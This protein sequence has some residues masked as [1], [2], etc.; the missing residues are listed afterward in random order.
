M[1]ISLPVGFGHQGRSWQELEYN[2]PVCMRADHSLVHQNTSF[3]TVGMHL[4]SGHRIKENQPPPKK[5]PN[6]L[7]KQ[8]PHMSVC[9]IHRAAQLKKNMIL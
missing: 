1:P 3:E 4:V 8:T 5:K 7:E 6:T 2:P 9:K